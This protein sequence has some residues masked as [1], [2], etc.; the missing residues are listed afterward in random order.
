MNIRASKFCVFGLILLIFVVNLELAV[1][2]K[3]EFEYSGNSYLC[4]VIPD[5]SSIEEN[6]FYG[7]T[8]DDVGKIRFNGTIKES[9]PFCQRFENVT[10]IDVFEKK[11]V[12]ESMFQ[13]CRYLKEA[14]ISFTDIEEIPEDL[15][16]EHYQLT[17]IYLGR[18]K[19]RTLP[20]NVFSNQE[21]LNKLYLDQN[22]I[23]C[24]PP[25]I[26]K[27]LTRLQI[28][29]LSENKIQSLNPKWFE[30]LQS[31]AELNLDFN[32]IQDL[33]R[34]VFAQ[35]DWL[36]WLYLE[37]NQLTTI[38]SDSFQIHRNLKLIDLT[39]NRINAI[40]EKFIDNVE[41]EWIDMRGNICNNEEIRERYYIDE[42]LRNCFNNYQ[43]R[44]GSSK[45]NH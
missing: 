17:H 2:L 24:L 28:L 27:S 11:S 6:H 26:F 45:Q 35:L 41:V 4:N 31:L 12:D 43:S 9:T 40:D 37:G 18:N 20:E 7:N 16:A 8:D 25:N 23:S 1:G 33:P 5:S 32:E 36:E 42:K 19:L 44:Q 14:G 34:N 38:Y 39:N 15:Y 13:Q 10:K 29:T 3:C 30:S 21:E 22:Q